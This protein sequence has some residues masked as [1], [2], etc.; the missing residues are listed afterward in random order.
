M[1]RSSLA[2][3]CPLLL[4]LAACLQDHKEIKVRPDGSGTLTVTFM[5]SKEALN[6]MKQMAQAFGGPGGKMEDPF[7]EE[8][9]KKDASTYGKGVNFVSA[10]KVTKGDFEGIKALYTF[11]DITKLTL[12][13]KPSNP[14]PKIP[15][16]PPQER[17]NLVFK[18]ETLANGNT[19]ITVVQPMKKPEEEQPSTPAPPAAPGG[20]QQLM[21]MKQMFKGLK[22]SISLAVDGTLVKTNT[23]HVEGNKLTIVEVEFDKLLENPEKFAELAKRQPKTLEDMK[24]VMKDVPGIKFNPEPQTTVEFK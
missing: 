17:E 21:M 6:Q 18:R 20:E 13:Q 7:S 3:V 5:M 4:G 9:A 1:R 23:P 2:V 8:K 14:G 12:D 19:L 22:F 10:E 15:G 16:Q 11:T 24:K